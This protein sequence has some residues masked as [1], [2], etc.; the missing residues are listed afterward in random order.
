MAY[1]ASVTEAKTRQPM[2]MV[3]WDTSGE[4]ADLHKLKGV[5]NVDC[6]VLCMTV[7]SPDSIRDI[8]DIWMPKIRNLY[9]GRPLVLAALRIDLRDNY[10]TLQMLA[11]AQDQPLSSAEGKRIMDRIGAA[12][13]FDC[14]VKCRE[15]V[16]D[17][18]HEVAFQGLQA[19]SD[20][21]RSKNLWELTKRSFRRSWKFQAV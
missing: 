16:Q 3:I 6:V 5:Q 13:Y 17:L 9:P 12:S 1:R 19:K 20:P 11:D 4:V 2:D 8:E 21:R 7:D 18:F 14:S 10:K 15:G